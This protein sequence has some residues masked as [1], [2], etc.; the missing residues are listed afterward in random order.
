MWGED[1]VGDRFERRAE[2]AAA[3]SA[4][5]SGYIA[6][7]PYPAGLSDA[8]LR[9]SPTLRAPDK[10]VLFLLNQ[11]PGIKKEVFCGIA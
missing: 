1:K 3:R 6:V 4:V 5:A 11:S 9:A 7:H 8:L 10:S 2:R